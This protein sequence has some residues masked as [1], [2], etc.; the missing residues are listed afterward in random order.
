MDLINIVSWGAQQVNAAPSNDLVTMIKNALGPLLSKIVMA[1]EGLVDAI[2]AASTST[3]SL[4]NEL[5]ALEPPALRSDEAGCM[6]PV[7]PEGLTEE[8]NDG[9]GSDEV[10]AGSQQSQR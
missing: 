1:V 7:D 5:N 4:C 8:P 9:T 6:P 3:Q 2:D 10:L